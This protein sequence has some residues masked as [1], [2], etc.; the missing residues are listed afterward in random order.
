MAQPGT[1]TMLPAPVESAEERLKLFNA[2]T[3]V[4]KKTSPVKALF[5]KIA[6]QDAEL[7]AVR[8]NMGETD[9]AINMEFRLWPDA[10]KAAA[11]ALVT[12]NAAITTLNAA[13]CQLNDTEARALAAA[14]HLHSTVLYCWYG[15][16]T[17]LYRACA[18]STHQHQANAYSAGLATKARI[19]PIRASQNH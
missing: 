18:T 9:N 5:E 7:K 4:V 17:V 1:L 15:S 2:E 12:G 19:A 10:R 8:L 11:L 13:G 6:Q 3:A 14:R 16:T